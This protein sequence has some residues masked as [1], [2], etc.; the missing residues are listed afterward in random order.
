MYIYSISIISIFDMEFNRKNAI[1][2]FLKAH[3]DQKFTSYGITEW[4]V[5]NHIDEARLKA[6]ASTNKRLLEAKTQEEKDKEIIGIDAGEISSSKLS[7]ERRQEPN[8]RIELKPKLKFYYSQKPDYYVNNEQA[9]EPKINANKEDKITAVQVCDAL[10]LYLQN[11]LK[12]HNMP[13]KHNFSSNKQGTKG[14]N[15]W[16]HPDWVGMEVINEKWSSL[17][18]DCA[19]YYAGK[20]A[21]LWSFEAKKNYQS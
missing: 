16:L 5:E 8:I 20:Q 10:A 19:K 21:R 15:K 18:K 7:A 9:T 12:I 3:E 14:N 6:N 4:L 13:I 11:K 2:G 17:I 1:I